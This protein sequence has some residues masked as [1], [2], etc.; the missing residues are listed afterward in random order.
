MI[1][2][3]IDNGHGVNTPGKH[4][5]IKDDGKR[6]YEWEHTRKMARAL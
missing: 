4:S 6:L 1:T 3:L 5:P 2:V